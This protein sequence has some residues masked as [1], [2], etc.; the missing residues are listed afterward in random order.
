MPESKASLGAPAAKPVEGGLPRP[1]SRRLTTA[2]AVIGLLALH[3]ALA[4]RSLIQENPTVDE[5]VHLPA[6][7]TYWQRGT[8]KLYHHN[9]PLVRM[10]AASRTVGKP[11]NVACV[12]G[13]ELAGGRSVPATTFSQTFAYYNQDRYFDLFRLA[14]MVMPL[15]SIVGGLVV[16]AWSSRLYGTSGGLLS[17][18]SLGLLP[19][20]SGALPAGDDH[21]ARR[22]WAAQRRSCSGFTCTGR[23]GG[24]PS[25][26]GSCS[27]SP[28]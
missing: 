6:G 22:R 18:A 27:G 20:Y 26:P 24:G 7:I 3:L 8:F 25:R 5:V 28:S 11:G 4:E 23:R 21:L 17:L 9:P 12:C 10:A 14:R 1:T 2:L 19:E 16:F 15:F 13:R